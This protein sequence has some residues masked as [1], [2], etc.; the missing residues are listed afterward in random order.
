MA[1]PGKPSASKW[2]SFLTSAVAGVESRLDN[3]LAEGAGGL[4]EDDS[5]GDGWTSQPKPKKPAAPQAQPQA[6][7]PMTAAAAPAPAQ[8]AKPGTSSCS[9]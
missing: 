9:Y 5:D 4:D 3:M 8:A 7:A 6:Q 2:G 1:A